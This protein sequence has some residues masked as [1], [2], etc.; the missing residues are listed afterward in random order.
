MTPVANTTSIDFADGRHNAKTGRT[1]F[2]FTL[3]FNHVYGISLRLVYGEV[4]AD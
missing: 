2:I 1:I 3:R 4:E